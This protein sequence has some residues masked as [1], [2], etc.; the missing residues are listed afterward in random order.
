MNKGA[1]WIKKSRGKMR[2][3]RKASVLLNSGDHLEMYYDEQ[4]LSRKPP[5]AVCLHDNEH[6][7]VWHKPPGLLSQGT[8]YGDHCSLLRQAELFF[9][10]RRE[11]F[12]VHWLDREVP[13]VMLIAHRRKSAAEL[14]AIFQKKEI[15]KEYRVEVIGNLYQY[16]NSGKIELPLDGKPATTD[17]KILSYDQKRDVSLAEV[18]IK[19]GRYHQIRRHFHMIGHPVLGDP[20][21]GRG[22]KNSDGIKL[23]AMALRFRCPFQKKRVKFKVGARRRLAPTLNLIF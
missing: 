12:P 4:L 22:N 5:D 2:R 11:I 7:S 17:F 10:P 8:K 18:I 20:R 14:S 19:T 13:G 9:R 21:Y 1:V 23:S 6:Y 3:L 15:E 16:D